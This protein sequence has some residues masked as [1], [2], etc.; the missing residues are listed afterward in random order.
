MATVAKDFYD[1]P[2]N[3][4]ADL[5]PY[6]IHLTRANGKH[7]ALDVLTN[8]L[9]TGRINGSSGEGF[10]KGKRKAACLMDVPFASLKDV[11]RSSNKGRYEPYG[12]VIMKTYAYR[13]GT[14]PV[15]Y[16]SNAE[17]NALNVPASEL[18][19]VVR[20]EVDATTRKW[21][22]WLHEREWRCPDELRLPSTI[23]AVLV[24]N[25]KDVGKL[26]AALADDDAE[27]A[28]KPSSIIPLEVICQGLVY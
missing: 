13:K 10:I 4:R 18:W 8:I 28:C 27:F 20:F 25:W 17:C 11:C 9:R 14:R 7:S 23:R 15:L 3:D 16:L 24:K 26:Q 19:R 21:I 1:L 6:L 2:F 22:S 12:V 5:T